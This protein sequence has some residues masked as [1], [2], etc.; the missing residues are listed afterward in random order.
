MFTHSEVFVLPL[1]GRVKNPFK[2]DETLDSV[3]D[4]VESRKDIVQKMEMLLSE[5]E[6]EI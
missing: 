3:E 1:K 2:K 6:R 5:K 4:P